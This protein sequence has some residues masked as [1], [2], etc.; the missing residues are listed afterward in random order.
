MIVKEK[1]WYTK[2]HQE[3]KSLIEHE[4]FDKL[5]K[6][7]ILEDA[8]SN[9]LAFQE[10][11]DKFFHV[12]VGGSNCYSHFFPPLMFANKFYI[13]NVVVLPSGAKL[14]QL[15]ARFEGDSEPVILEAIY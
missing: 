12:L 14:F 15:T 9:R 8:I 6:K 11:V 4:L 10:S 3:L 2:H 13:F 5:A 7:K 1:G